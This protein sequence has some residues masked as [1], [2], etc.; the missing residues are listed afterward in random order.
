[1]TD[2]HTFLGAACLVISAI[3]IAWSTYWSPHD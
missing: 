1:M 3:A 2:P